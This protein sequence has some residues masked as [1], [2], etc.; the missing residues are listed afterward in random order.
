MATESIIEIPG[1]IILIICLLRCLQY[2]WKSH[3]KKIQAFWLASALIFLTVIRRELS[4]LPDLFVP[5]DF[6]FLNH[7]YYWWEHSTLFVISLI[8]LGLLMYAWQYLW[9]VLKNVNILLYITVAIL[10][11]IQYMGENAIGFPHAFGGILEEVCETAIYG[12]ALVYLWRLNF[13]DYADSFN[14]ASEQH[15]QTSTRQR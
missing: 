9:S 14:D 5:N 7:S 10:A 2:V 13:N 1:N 11:I 12:I 3:V 8:S 15:Y 4:Y 6:S